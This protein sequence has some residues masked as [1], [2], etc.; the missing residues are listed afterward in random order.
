MWRCSFLLLCGY[1]FPTWYWLAAHIFW[2]IIIP[3]LSFSW[4]AYMGWW[5]VPTKLCRFADV[6]D[7]VLTQSLL[8]LQ[9]SNLSFHHQWSLFLASFC[10]KF[11]PVEKILYLWYYNTTQLHLLSTVFIWS[12]TK[13]YTFTDNIWYEWWQL[14]G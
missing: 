11:S 3:M 2:V 4:D 1:C 8:P 12:T 13:S 6:E 14:Q 7:L 9:L 5:W 10:Y